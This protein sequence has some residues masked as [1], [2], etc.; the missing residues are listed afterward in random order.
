MNLEEVRPEVWT[1]TTR[2]L[3]KWLRE[4]DEVCKIDWENVD[5]DT[6]RLRVEI[7][8]TLEYR[9]QDPVEELANSA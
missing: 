4:I 9:A 2:A 8:W 5:D 6:V 3:K 7:L 1:A